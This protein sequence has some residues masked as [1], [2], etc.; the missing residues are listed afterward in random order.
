[1]TQEA[2]VQSET[3]ERVPDQ[4]IT[5]TSVC[6]N[7][8]YEVIALEPGFAKVRFQTRL[9]EKIDK[10]SYIYEASIFSCAN[11]AAIA[12]IN[13]PQN[14]LISARVD[15]LNP[16]QAEDEEVIFEATASTNSSGKKEV[17]VAGFVK[18][19]TVFES[20]FVTLKLDK[21][22]ILKEEPKT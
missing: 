16:I 22:S 11:F 13:E 7:H 1:M 8:S 20:R 10:T 15:F 18:G 2:S 9:A 17:Q 12:A 5:H 19:I 6:E 3:T 14:H 4:L 21:K